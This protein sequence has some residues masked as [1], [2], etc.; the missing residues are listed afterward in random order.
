VYDASNPR[1]YIVQ[2]FQDGMIDPEYL[3]IGLAK[4][5]SQDEAQQFLEAAELVPDADESEDTGGEPL[6]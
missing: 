1:D 2:L 4:F 6:I 3:V 5:L